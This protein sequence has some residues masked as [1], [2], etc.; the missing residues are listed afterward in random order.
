MIFQQN[1]QVDS[2]LILH[3]ETNIAYT[4]PTLLFGNKNNNNIVF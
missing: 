2:M 1:P 3:T 4:E